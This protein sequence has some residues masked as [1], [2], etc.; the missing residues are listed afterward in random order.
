MTDKE[1]IEMLEERNAY[2]EHQLLASEH[3]LER[4]AAPLDCAKMKFA[5]EA[6]LDQPYPHRNPDGEDDY[7]E[8]VRLIAKEGLE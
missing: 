3:V 2:L 8:T 7:V 4:L 5:L 1:K 6:I